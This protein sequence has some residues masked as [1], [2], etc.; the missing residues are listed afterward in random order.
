MRTVRCKVHHV[1]LPPTPSFTSPVHIFCFTIF[2]MNMSGSSST[3]HNGI[4]FPHSSV[5]YTGLA[6][7][8]KDLSSRLSLTLRVIHTPT[9]DLLFCDGGKLRANMRDMHGMEHIID[10]HLGRRPHQQI[11]AWRCRGRYDVAMKADMSLL[12]FD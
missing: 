4:L 9:Y 5:V 6:L 1:L 7:V 11:G 8:Q 2:R 12:L 3:H 10:I